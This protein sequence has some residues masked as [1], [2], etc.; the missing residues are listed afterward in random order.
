MKVEY[1]QVKEDYA[2]LN[3]EISE[4]KAENE[5]LKADNGKF[6]SMID[7]GLGWED[8]VNDI[9]PNGQ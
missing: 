4:L 2:R 1:D 9:K 8:M 3:A 5:R 7:C 6:I